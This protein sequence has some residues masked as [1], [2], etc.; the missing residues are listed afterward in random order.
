MEFDGIE[1]VDLA[2]RARQHALTD[3]LWQTLEA[4]Q[5]GTNTI[6][7]I[8]A[9]LTFQS[10]DGAETFCAAYDDDW[11]T[12]I[13]ENATGT[14]WLVEILTPECEFTRLAFIELVDVLMIDAAH[15][16]GQFD[17]FQLE[18]HNIRKRQWWK[19]WE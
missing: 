10:R 6:G 14:G 16:S 12:E 11:S 3:A 5:I 13:R 2:E 1:T 15:T 19:F 7:R 8:T 18:P 17:G 4:N 9:L